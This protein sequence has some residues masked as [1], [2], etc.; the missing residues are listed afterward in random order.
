MAGVAAAE[1]AIEA[2][3]ADSHEV[4]SP[5]VSLIGASSGSGASAGAEPIEIAPRKPLFPVPRS[6]SDANFD[7]DGDWMDDAS[8]LTVSEGD[9]SISI[10]ASLQFRYTGSWAPAAPDTDP[11][12][13]FQF[14]R[15]RPVLRGSGVDGKLK[16]GIQTE[17]NGNGDVDLLDAWVSFQITDEL[18]F[19]TGR[20]NLQYDRELIT[21]S[22]YLPMVERS[23][24]SNTLN[25]D[26]ANRVE[27]VEFRYEQE[28]QRLTVTF[29][30]GLGVTGTAFN[31]SRS[32]WGITGRYERLL[33]GDDFKQQTQI[34]APRGTPRSLMLGFAAHQQHL[35]GLGERFSAT[36]DLTYKHDGFNATLALGAQVS[37]DRNGPV[38][39]EPEHDW[40][41]TLGSGYYITER[42]EPFARL[43]LGTTSGPMHP[44]LAIFTT[45]FNW[46]ILGQALKFSTDFSVAFN[47]IG[48]AFDRAADGF[49]ETPDGDHRYV[50]RAQIQMLF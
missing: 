41:M 29:G 46:Y 43:E 49:I 8:P 27:G 23:V 42:V 22:S 34:T 16:F 5:S 44:D 36:T 48:P 38:F 35:H 10:G 21:S 4:G 6:I 33:I 39:R 14:R 19:R 20:F 11:E 32:D 26:A 28:I 17:A 2:E 12:L 3:P 40:G 45:G 37:E 47:G 13:G 9:F 50:W 24:L 7:S 15:L 30:E 1:P 18:R 31:D 25:V